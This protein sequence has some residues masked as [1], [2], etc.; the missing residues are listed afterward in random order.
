MLRY[1]SYLE[2]ITVAGLRMNHQPMPGL[3]LVFICP[4]IVCT[5]ESGRMYQ[6]MR[7]VNGRQK[8][9]AINFGIYEV[10]D[11]LDAQGP[12][13]F[14]ADKA[15]VLEPL[16]V[17][18]DG[19]TV[20]YEGA[21]FSLQFSPR[22]HKWI[23]ASGDVELAIEH[24]GKVSTFWIPKQ[25]LSSHPQMLR[26][27]MGRVTGAI[28]GDRVTGLFMVDFIYS[29]P[30]LLW[31]E[32]GMMTE[33]HNVWLNWMV[34]YEDGGYEGGLAWRGRPGT[35]FAAAHHI[36][37]GVSAARC[38]AKI[39]LETTSRGTPTKVLLS[40]GT[41]T[42]VELTQKGSQDWPMHTCG[43]VT[44]INRDR[45]IKRSWNYT[46]FY[47]LNWPDVIAYFNAYEGL[48]GRAPSWRKT[49]EG[50]RIVDQRV[51]WG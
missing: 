15:P 38:D 36:V 22:G 3:A 11:E 17:R 41:D 9:V 16:I 7:G 5:G 6:L 50:A 34:E 26:S 32:M 18:D 25:K 24:V 40:L 33:L 51:V 45:K 20:A 21:H 13:Y 23:D 30:E 12:F 35:N 29:Q 19:E 37:D 27:H 49:F 44:Q 46:E 48:Y 4:F 1:Q 8:G 14:K 43:F 10:T 28:G 31:N 42:H 2:D 39:E 47:P